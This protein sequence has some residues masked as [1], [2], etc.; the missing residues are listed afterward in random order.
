MVAL[1]AQVV[2]RIG[3]PILGV[4]IPAAI[5]TISFV[6]AFLLFRHFTRKLKD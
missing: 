4:I 6:V 1:L 3:S 5:F 2:E